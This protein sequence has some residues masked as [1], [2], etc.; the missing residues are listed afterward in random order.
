MM[1]EKL[2]YVLACAA[3]Y[4]SAAIESIIEE[5]EAATEQVSA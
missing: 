4:A 2:L 5:D 1:M 3:L